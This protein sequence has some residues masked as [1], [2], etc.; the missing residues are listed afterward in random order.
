MYKQRDSKS[1]M[2]MGRT[3]CSAIFLCFF[4]LLTCNIQCRPISRITNDT[5]HPEESIKP[6]VHKLGGSSSFLTEAKN[7]GPSPGEGHGAVHKRH[8]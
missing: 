3:K 5:L 8:N 7:S 4:L 2:K 1:N 6:K